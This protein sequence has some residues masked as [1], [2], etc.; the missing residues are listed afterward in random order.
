VLTDTS[1]ERRRRAD[2]VS[3][4]YG[5]YVSHRWQD[6]DAPASYLPL[7]SPPVLDASQVMLRGFR[8]T[9][10]DGW[11]RLTLPWMRLELE[12]AVLIGAIEQASLIPGVLLNE[13]VDSLQVGLALES[14][15]GD[16]DGDIVGGLDLG[17]ASGDPAPGFGVSPK[18]TDAMPQPG[19]LDGAQTIPGRDSRVDNFRFHPDYRVD[20]ILFR[21][22]IGTITDAAYFRPHVEWRAAEIGP[23]MLTL[24]LAA[25]FSLAVDAHSTPGGK[26]PLG[27]EIDPTLDYLTHDGFGFGIDYAVLFPLAGLDNALQGIGSA[28]AQLTRFRV[29][30]AF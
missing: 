27:I 2:R 22:I 23:G 20:R 9:A 29:S 4:E 1:R 24:K 19:D 12:T 7:G 16:P 11:F 6:N 18:A 13:S 14:S 17:F 28:P 25:V 5:A 26:Q 15:F 30:Y 3:V 21:E 8:A 10:V